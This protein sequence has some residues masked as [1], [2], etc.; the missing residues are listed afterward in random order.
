MRS[1][2]R[3]GPV[4]WW[5]LPPPTPKSSQQKSQ[6][7]LRRGGLNPNPNPSSLSST[8]STRISIY[9]PRQLSS[10]NV[11]L[12]ES[13]RGTM[14]GRGRGRPGTRQQQPAE[15]TTVAVRRATRLQ[16]QSPPPPQGE[17]AEQQQLQQQQQQVQD[18]QIDPA[19]TGTQESE[20]PPPPVPAPKGQSKDS[21]QAFVEVARRSTRRDAR[22]GS[23][24]SVN[25]VLTRVSG[26]DAF[27]SQ[28]ET[29]SKSTWSVCQESSY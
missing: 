2:E 15:G 28:P 23:M 1:R 14:T 12:R 4:W 19:I 18:A 5:G 11:L 21:E 27:S 22:A 16:Q 9:L 25:S 7:K 10:R 26:T 20:M 24:V 3:P 29:P 13:L 8:T 17:Q 6:N